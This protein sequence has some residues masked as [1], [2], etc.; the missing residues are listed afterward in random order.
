M[1]PPSAEKVKELAFNYLQFW[2]DVSGKSVAN[3]VVGVQEG[4]KEEDD[5]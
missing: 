3:R 4:E 2:L 5:D 1:D